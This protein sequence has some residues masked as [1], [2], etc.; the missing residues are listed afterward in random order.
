METQ[1]TEFAGLVGE[2]APMVSHFTPGAGV[3][4]AQRLA[5]V[6]ANLKY[7]R[8][9]LFVVTIGIFIP[10]GSSLR[11]GGAYT[12]RPLTAMNADFSGLALDPAS[13]RGPV[14]GERIGLTRNSVT[15]HM[16]VVKIF[17]LEKKLFSLSALIERKLILRRS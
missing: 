11:F 8:M 3:R 16:V 9:V 1:I 2:R 7:I 10:I 15:Y 12:S 14:R 5:T 13:R 4:R 6:R 17:S